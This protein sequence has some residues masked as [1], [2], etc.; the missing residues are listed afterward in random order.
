MDSNLPR[1]TTIMPPLVEVH[2]DGSCQPPHRGVAG[3]GFVI[4][5]EGL[6]YSE[7]GLAAP[8]Y[9]ETSTNNVAE[10]VG[11][12]RALEHLRATEFRGQVVLLGDSELVIKQLNG[13]YEVRSEHL[14]A[15]H[16]RLK[17][18]L[19]SFRE[20]RIE[21]VPREQNEEADV[22]SKLAVQEASRDA[23]RYRSGR[24]TAPSE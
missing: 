17:T 8:P 22:L 2:F 9:S 13:E 21:W 19:E 3:Y 4:R 7:R 10:Y 5:G 14:K 16:H 20:V 11:A 23:R 12:I 1:G 24:P 18:L 6:D 15:Y